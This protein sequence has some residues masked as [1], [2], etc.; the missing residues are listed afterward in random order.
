MKNYD[1]EPSL[2][3]RSACDEAYIYIYI[4][5]YILWAMLGTHEVAQIVMWLVMSSKSRFKRIHFYYSQLDTW[6]IMAKMVQDII[7]N[8]RNT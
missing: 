4:Y 6:Q 5:I 3:M 7:S 2:H 1:T 8:A